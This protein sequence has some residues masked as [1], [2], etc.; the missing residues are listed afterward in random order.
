MLFLS[1]LSFDK[2]P[3]CDIRDPLVQIINSHSCLEIFKKLEFLPVFVLF[4][5]FMKSSPRNNIYLPP[6]HPLCFLQPL[7]HYFFQNWEKLL[8]KNNNNCYYNQKTQNSNNDNS[9]N[10][11]FNLV[12]ETGHNRYCFHCEYS[13]QSL[14]SVLFL[15]LFSLP[16]A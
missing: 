10:K 4:M 12:P 2:I 11:Y 1:F 13:L 15:L 8:D 5:N 16:N 9:H 6:H 14:K 7:T 3:S